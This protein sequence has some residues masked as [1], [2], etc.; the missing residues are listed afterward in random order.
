MHPQLISLPVYILALLGGAI[1]GVSLAGNTRLKWIALAGIGGALLGFGISYSQP[2]GH[3]DL[4]VQSYGTLMLI[5]FMVG[6]YTSARRAPL[7]GVDK[8]HCVDIGVYGV[9][10]GLA[11]ARVLHIVSNWPEFTPFIETGFSTE[12][13]VK[14]FKLWE[15]GLDFFGTF[16]TVIP[17]TYLYCVQ[18]KIPALPFVDMSCSS[19]IFG[20]AFGRIGCF[21]Y[22]CCYGKRCSLPWGVRFPEGAPV[23]EHQFRLGDIGANALSSLSVHPT[24]IYAS[25]ACLLTA[26]FLYAY[27]PRRP[28]DGFMLALMMIMTGSMRFFEELLRDDV[29]PAFSA[30]PWLT[31]A[32][33]FALAVVSGG[34]GLMLFFRRRRTLFKPPEKGRALH[35]AA[36]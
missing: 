36:S 32:H 3:Q 11:G 14:M 6:V 16:I 34:I 8:K 1:L 18:F 27:W 20:Q 9:A 29:P 31:P 30:V 7:L 19:L 4:P 35:A 13:I 15:A 12:R 2:W 17:F 28:Y 24:Q 23:Y 5:G 10:I 25:I 33:Y 26:C 21:L 22:G